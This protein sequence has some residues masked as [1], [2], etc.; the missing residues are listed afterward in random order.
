MI[1]WPLFVLLPVPQVQLQVFYIAE[2]VHR[3]LSVMCG[4]WNVGNAQP[5]G[6]LDEW[7]QG[8]KEAHHDLVAIGVATQHCCRK[9]WAGGCALPIWR[10]MYGC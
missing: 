10:A 4:T 2:R 9:A 3:P 6:D 7:L 1:F 5:P 8:V